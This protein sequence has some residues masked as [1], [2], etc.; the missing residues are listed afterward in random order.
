MNDRNRH[1]EDNALQAPQKLVTALKALTHD[2]IFIPPAIDRVIANAARQR[3]EKPSGARK[4]FSRWLLWPALATACVAFA[5]LL[6]LTSR[7][8]NTSTF[9]REDLNRDGRVDILD[10]FALARQIRDGGAAPAALD[11]NGDGVVNQRD[12]EIIAAR[13]V[14]LGKGDRS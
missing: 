1:N 9:A 3:L 11:L 6:F 5:L 8:S 10:A 7:L 12:T 2:R 4:I 13:A 14:A